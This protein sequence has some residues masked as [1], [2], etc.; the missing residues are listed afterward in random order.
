MSEHVEALVCLSALPHG[1]YIKEML[2]FGNLYRLAN[3]YVNKKLNGRGDLCRNEEWQMNEWGLFTLWMLRSC[4]AKFDFLFKAVLTS[5]LWHWRTG[6]LWLLWRWGTS[7]G[8]LWTDEIMWDCYM[9]RAARSRAFLSW[10][11]HHFPEWY[12]TRNTQSHA[13]FTQIWLRFIRTA[14]VIFSSVLRQWCLLMLVLQDPEL[15]TPWALLKASS[16]TALLSFLS[17]QQCTTSIW[18][19]GPDRCLTVEQG[20]TSKQECFYNCYSGEDVWLFGLCIE[21]HYPYPR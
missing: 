2:H 21:Q 6:G 14:F 11:A 13:R 4:C 7:C 9:E 12:N 8:W 19:Q 20:S 17:S 1:S 18:S 10:G 5:K 3:F 16:R 15:F